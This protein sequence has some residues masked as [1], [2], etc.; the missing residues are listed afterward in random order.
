MATLADIV[1]GCTVVG[2][3][4]SARATV[5]DASWRAGNQA[6]QVVYRL[7]DG[8]LGQRM[9]F[10]AEA[11]D[12]SL[13][14]EPRWSF[15]A[16]PCDF[17]LAA[18]GRRMQLAHLYD[19]F[20][21]VHASAVEPLPHQISAVYE[22][23]L[24]RIPLRF[25]LADDP[26]AG[27]TIMTGL[28]VKEM[29]ARG[30]LKRCLVVCPGNLVEQ[31]QDELNEKF[32]LRFTIMTNDA[33]EASVG[34]NA[35]A[36][37]DLAI[38]RLDKL[39]RSDEVQDLLRQTRWDLIVCDEAHKMSATMGADGPKTT[40]RFRLGKLLGTLTPNLLLLTATPHN[41]KPQEFQ[42]FMSLVDQDQFEGAVRN[43][44][45]SIDAQSSMR[46]LVKE[47]LLKFDS[48][49]LFPERRAYTVRYTLS[50]P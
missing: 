46:R 38:A 22:E 45:Q 23:M 26:G 3:A 5:V 47:D 13:I 35:F 48:T 49:P 42:L 18:E 29:L 2:L 28:L 17:R 24:P 39:A 20:L 1:K 9:V 44:G 12:I 14:D 25:V 7:P 41:G 8:T 36:E 11:A 40:K 10:A 6:K 50:P 16:D 15:E 32:G 30:D 27:K 19:P 43:E 34:R 4:G 21:A 37:I 31:W 33:L